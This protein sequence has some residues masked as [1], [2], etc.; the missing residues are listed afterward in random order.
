MKTLQILLVGILFSF[1]SSVYADESEIVEQL[2]KQAEPIIARR[3]KHGGRSQELK[4][5]LDLLAKEKQ[6]VSTKIAALNKEEPILDKAW[7][8]LKMEDHESAPVLSKAWEKLEI[9]E[10]ESD[11]DFL[12]RKEA[13]R[14]KAQ[15][16]FDLV[17]AEW[18]SKKATDKRAS[19]FEKKKNLLKEKLTKEYNEA[20]IVWK[21]K[22]TEENKK[23]EQIEKSSKVVADDLTE[24]INKLSSLKDV[25]SFTLIYGAKQISLPKFNRNKMAFEIELLTGI[26]EGKY[27]LIRSKKAKDLYVKIDDLSKYQTKPYEVKFKTLEEAKRFKEL[28]ESNKVFLEQKFSLR[29]A[30]IPSSN[31]AYFEPGYYKAEVTKMVDVEVDKS[32]GRVVAESAGLALLFSVFGGKAPSGVNLADLLAT[33]P[34]TTTE[35]KQVVTQPAISK[36]EI[37]VSGVSYNF[38]VNEC[39]ASISSST[40]ENNIVGEVTLVASISN[41]SKSKD[42]AQSNN[43]TDMKPD[44]TKVISLIEKEMVLVPSG[45]FMMGSPAS[46]KDRLKDETQHEVT[47][48]KSYYMG[49]YEVTQE[50]WEAVMGDNPSRTKGAKLPVTDVS[51]DDCQEFIKK[52]NAKTD[53]GYR[54]P[55]EAEW[56][57]AC[58]AGTTTAYSFGNQITDKDVNIPT[59]RTIQ[60]EDEHNIYVIKTNSPNAVGGFK[61]NA[62]GLFDMHGNVCEWCADWYGDYPVGPL[63]DPK[64]PLKG[65]NHVVRGGGFSRSYSSE[66]TISAPGVK[67]I[68]TKTKVTEEISFRPARS[69]ARGAWETSLVPRDVIGFRLV[70]SK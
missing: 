32:L 49:K 26:T 46:E 1:L 62:F 18:K 31:P 37:K 28:F 33:M 8:L 55:T 47:I 10:F 38:V 52:L 51:W 44:L 41:S 39:K 64:G 34:K 66:S 59:S 50:Q 60:Y 63:T 9:G 24:E 61:P 5:Q 27:G 58:R 3:E 17:Y 70:K 54:L 2:V 45:K 6:A 53:G 67:P 23:L 68:F 29:V 57:Y 65:M 4:L 21:S 13:A 7:E 36:P 40:G 56:E 14:V 35:R 43:T 69:S 48:T 15:K 11:K 12:T 20:F 30:N 16:E 22:V 25:A 19:D 42:T